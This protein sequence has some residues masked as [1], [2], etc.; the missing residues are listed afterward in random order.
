MSKP[1]KLSIISDVKD[2]LR[3]TKNIGDALEDVA[4]SLDDVSDG[5]EASARALEDSARRAAKGL[6]RLGDEGKDTGKAVERGL[7]RAD[8]ALKDTGRESKRTQRTFSEAAK[9]M[10][11]DAKDAG[12]TIGREISEGAE[13]AS[14]GIDE[15]KDEAAESAREMAASFSGSFDDVVD[16]AQEVA[17]Q[18]FKGFGPAGM[19]AGIAA[20][21]GL[22]YL[23]SRMQESAEETAEAKQQVLDLADA[24]N[25]VKGDPDALDWAERLR[26]LLKEIVDEKSW[27][28]FWQDEPVT[29][30]EEWSDAAQRWGFDVRDATRAVRGDTEAYQRVLDALNRELDKTAP[31]IA[32]YARAGNQAS[33]EIQQNYYAATA[34]RDAIHSFRAALEEQVGVAGEAVDVNNQ[35]NDAI[36]QIPD[37]V[38]EAQEATSAY[39]S[40]VVDALTSAG[41]AWEAYTTDGIVNLSEYN[42]AIEEQAAA[43]NAF[44]ENLVAA[45][46]NLSAEA[47]NYIKN[48]GP[49][50]APLLQAF[51]DA[52]LE[53]KQRTAQNWDTVGRAATD[54]YAQSLR[55]TEKT[56]QATAD[57][58]RAADGHPIRFKTELQD[59]LQAQVNQ[60]ARSIHAPTIEVP[61]RP[62]IT[63]D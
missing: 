63:V 48:L 26:E 6:D 29:R 5:G 58:Q 21:V 19:A 1:F 55:L 49:D 11:H 27:Y 59:T 25:D 37:A 53:E 36:G 46:E 31:A 35:L 52:P 45:S 54:G 62:R 15:M 41:G 20:A 22:G 23:I 24:I 18:A 50:A 39:E 13:E 60:A 47:L 40:A 9:K 28:E 14:E 38:L 43:V 12:D 51:I 10:R 34:A 7:E 8:K 56:N 4:D 17:A 30:L 42:A 44:E 16:V 3:G 32:A 57:A 33:T 61:I 2:F